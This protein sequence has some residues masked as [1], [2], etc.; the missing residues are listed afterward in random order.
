M[1][2]LVHLILAPLAAPLETLLL[3][4]DRSN[5]MFPSIDTAAMKS[6]DWVKLRGLELQNVGNLIA[7]SGVEWKWSWR[8]GGGSSSQVLDGLS[9]KVETQGERERVREEWRRM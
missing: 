9:Y 3:S 7:Q 6:W 8:N 4:C 1:R 2:L 5:G